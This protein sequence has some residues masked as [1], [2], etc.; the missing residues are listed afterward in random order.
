MHTQEPNHHF[1]FSP[2]GTVMP[3]EGYLV[4]PEGELKFV[5]DA[6]E[7]LVTLANSGPV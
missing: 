5:E 3:S 4:V 7:T 6:K 2:L 1:F